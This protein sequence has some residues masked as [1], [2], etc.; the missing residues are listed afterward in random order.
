MTKRDYDEGF[1]NIYT[2]KASQ[3]AT[4]AQSNKL[5]ES[6]F[7]EMSVELAKEA[8]HHISILREGSDHEATKRAMVGRIKI[9]AEVSSDVTYAASM[10]KIAQ[11][12]EGIAL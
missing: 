12:I 10:K 1:I 9:F 5:S 6:E 3:L 7:L 4:K 11:D 8:V 2:T